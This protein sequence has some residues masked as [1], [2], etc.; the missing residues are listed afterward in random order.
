MCPSPMVRER[1]DKQL[2][3]FHNAENMFGIDMAVQMRHK[4][5][6]GTSLNSRRKT[7]VRVAIF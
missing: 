7:L 6:P 5:Q 2:N 3:L 1:I 4:K